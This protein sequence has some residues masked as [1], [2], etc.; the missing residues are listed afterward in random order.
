MAL[1]FLQLCTCPGLLIKGGKGEGDQDAGPD[2]NQGP[3]H[4]IARIHLPTGVARWESC[5]SGSLWVEYNTCLG[6]L[7]THMDKKYV[8]CKNDGVCVCVCVCVCGFSSFF[9]Y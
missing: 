1:Y 4:A 5:E 8:S 2:Q 9:S 6:N 7:G 3:W